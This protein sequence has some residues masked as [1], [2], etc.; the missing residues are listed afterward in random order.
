MEFARLVACVLCLSLTLPVEAFTASVREK[1]NALP[2]GA[3][4]EVKTVT[5]SK[6]KGALG[7]TSDQSFQ[8]GP[9]TI[10]Y[11]EVKQ[12]KH[13]ARDSGSAR[14]GKAVLWTLAGLGAVV[15]VFTLWATASGG[16]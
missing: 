12:V 7:E 10:R 13:L 1:V 14:A 11:D 6:W 16:D 8:V 3:M 15:L 9:A 5:G 4:V 2:A